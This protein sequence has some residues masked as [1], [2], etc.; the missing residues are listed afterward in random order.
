MNTPRSLWLRFRRGEGFVSAWHIDMRDRNSSAPEG[1]PDDE[2]F[3]GCRNWN[4]GD[5]G[6][7]VHCCLPVGVLA[8]EKE[9]V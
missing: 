4:G 3:D 7:D 6:G 9:C 2:R 1:G 8:C 5:G